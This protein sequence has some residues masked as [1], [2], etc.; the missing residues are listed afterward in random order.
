MPG[1]WHVRFLGGA[2]YPVV[3]AIMDIDLK[4]ID[5]IALGT[6]IPFRENKDSFTFSI[7]KDDHAFEVQILKNGQYIYVLLILIDQPYPIEHIEFYMNESKDEV[8]EELLWNLNTL[9]QNK[10][11]I[12][13]HKNWLR[14]KRIKVEILKNNTWENFGYPVNEKIKKAST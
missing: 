1:N 4:D 8:L 7:Q 9:N 10:T 13:E 6:C 2:S 12:S 3:Q 14:S 5:K 11:K